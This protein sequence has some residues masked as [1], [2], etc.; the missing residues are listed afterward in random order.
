MEDY[1][2][3]KIDHNHSDLRIIQETVKEEHIALRY[4]I[5]LFNK[6]SMPYTSVNY[7]FVSKVAGSKTRN[8]IGKD[9]SEQS[10]PQFNN[11]NMTKIKSLIHTYIVFRDA[12]VLPPHSLFRIL[13]HHIAPDSASN[14]SDSTG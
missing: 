4:C 11:A 1:Y 7:I 9:T 5:D 8:Q 3:T 6:A 2:D 10:I 12:V 13:S 14:I